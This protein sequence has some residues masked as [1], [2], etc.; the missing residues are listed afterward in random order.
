MMRVFW[1][2]LLKYSGLWSIAKMGARFVLGERPYLNLRERVSTPKPRLQVQQLRTQLL[3]VRAQFKSHV[4]RSLS[5]QR[6]LEKELAQL[7]YPS[8]YLQDLDVTA[9]IVRKG[10]MASA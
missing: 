2:L 9:E 8:L 10:E 3:D 7:K 4:L 1:R 5:R 6:A